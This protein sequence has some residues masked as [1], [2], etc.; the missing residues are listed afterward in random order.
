MDESVQQ[1]E[2]DD[3]QRRGSRVIFNPLNPVGNFAID[4]LPNYVIVQ[5]ARHSRGRIFFEYFFTI[6]GIIIV[7][8]L[9]IA[10]SIN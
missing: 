9:V 1:Q 4:R 2:H 6:F 8:G 5:E 10:Y 7:V 3:Y